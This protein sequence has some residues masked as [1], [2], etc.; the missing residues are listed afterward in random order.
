MTGRKK[1][2]GKATYLGL[3]PASDLRYG[4]SSIVLGGRS[5]SQ[6]SA[7]PSQPRPQAPSP[8]RGTPSTKPT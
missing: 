1:N 4:E 3:V 6:S 7:K 5:S 8:K 2:K